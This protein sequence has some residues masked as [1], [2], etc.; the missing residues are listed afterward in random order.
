MKS[1]KSNISP[2]ELIV[3]I[4]VVVA[5]IVGI[6]EIIQF[7]IQEKIPQMIYLFLIHLLKDRIICGK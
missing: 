7:W 2:W 5:L 1:N 4:G 6:I 3:R